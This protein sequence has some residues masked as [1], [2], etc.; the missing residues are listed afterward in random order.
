MTVVCR[1]PASL[2]DVAVGQV[3]VRLPCRRDDRQHGRMVALKAR[4]AGIAQIRQQDGQPVA[5]VKMC[6]RSGRPKSGGMSWF[7]RRARRDAGPISHASTRATGPRRF[8]QGHCRRQ[9]RAAPQ[10]RDAAGMVIAIR[11]LLLQHWQ[12]GALGLSMGCLITSKALPCR[13]HGPQGR[14]QS[15][16]RCAGSGFLCWRCPLSCCR[17]WRRERWSSGP[18]GRKAS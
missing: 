17:C 9:D 8:G 1:C 16:R 3:R 18:R 2:R 15:R 13:S 4:G 5:V 10:P 12:A 6:L 7:C 11:P 14:P